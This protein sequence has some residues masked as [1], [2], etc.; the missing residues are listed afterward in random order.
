MT[1]Q[2]TPE[3]IS[4]RLTRLAD[5]A[6]TDTVS[7]NWV[8]EQLDDRAFGLFLLVL[9]LPCCLP[10]LYGLPQIV[11][12]PMLFIAVQYMI[13]RPTPWLPDRLGKREVSKDGLQRLANRAGPWLR[14]IEAISRP[15]LGALTAPPL[16]RVVAVML[17]IFCATILFPFPLTNSVPAFAVAVVAFGLLQRDGILVI[18]GGIIGVIWIGLLLYAGA[19]LGTLVRGWLGI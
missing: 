10:F 1:D 8:L 5:E 16:E 13:G 14:R 19:T 15:R 17:V 7:L 2:A 18:L 4:E 12:L 6:E 3:A 9:A 11:A